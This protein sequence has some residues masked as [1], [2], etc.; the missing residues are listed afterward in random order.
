MV[1]LEYHKINTIFK[2]DL[3]GKIL[4]GE[5]SRPE[6]EYLKDLPWRAT[7]KIDGTNIRV[8]WDGKT[9]TYGGKTDKADPLQP[10]LLARLNELFG[11]K[12]E[13]FTEL[14]K[15][16][17]VTLF[18]EGYGNRIQAVGKR[19]IPDNNDF[20]LFDINIGGWWLRDE[21][22]MELANK[23]CVRTVPYFGLLTLIDALDLIE[24]IDLTSEISFDKSLP[25]EGFVLKPL[26]D[27]R[28]RSGERIITKIKVKD[29][30][31]RQDERRYN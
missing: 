29:L 17:P 8:I 4:Y 18:G 7:E 27:L 23:L 19:Y 16:A 30:K 26:V 10:Q 3:K 1:N 28:A 21:D 6:F 11:G 2:R 20:V 5:W 22:L 13:L 31:E 9:I 12:E 14:F 15:D 24:G 25:I